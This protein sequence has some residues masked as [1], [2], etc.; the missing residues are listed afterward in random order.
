MFPNSS[1]E[2]RLCFSDVNL[3]LFN[4]LVDGCNYLPALNSDELVIGRQVFFCC[5]QGFFAS[6]SIFGID[7]SL[8]SIKAGLQESDFINPIIFSFARVVAHWSIQVFIAIVSLP[9]WLFASCLLRN[10]VSIRTRAEI[11]SYLLVM[12]KVFDKVSSLSQQVQ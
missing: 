6:R 2:T 1:L 10:Q 11:L 9:S 5:L 4:Y 8:A 12:S 3:F 7:I